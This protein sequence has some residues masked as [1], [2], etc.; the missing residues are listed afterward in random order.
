MNFKDQDLWVDRVSSWKSATDLVPRVVHNEIIKSELKPD[1]V[2]VGPKSLM[3]DP[4]SLQFAMGYKD[5]RYSLTYDV[6]KRIPQQLS[7]LAA[8]IQTR[9]NQVASF[10]VPF[11]LSKSLGFA[12]KHKNPARLTTKGEREFIQSLERFIYNCGA[13]APNPHNPHARDDFETFL[14]KVVRD[15]LMF[16]QL[17][18]EVVPDRKGQPYEFLA[19]DA[20]TIRIASD[21]SDLDFASAL[22]HANA[23][24]QGYENRALPQNTYGGHPYKT[25]KVRNP[26]IHDVPAYIQLLNGQIR[27]RYSRAELAFGVRNPRTDIYIQGYGYSELEQLITIITAHLF[28]EEY[29]RRFFMQGCVSG[30]TN[31]YSD[32]GIARI[33]SLVGQKLRVWNG[34]EFVDA[35]VV[36]SGIKRGFR[37]SL[38]S[39]SEIITTK[40]HKY[41]TFD[42]AGS[43]VMKPLSELSVGDYVAQSSSLVDFGIEPA[44]VQR[45]TYHQRTTVDAGTLDKDFYEFIGYLVGDGYISKL[46]RNKSSSKNNYTVSC[47]FGPKDTE[48]KDRFTSMLSSRGFKYH[49]SKSG[50][51]IGGAPLDTLTIRNKGLFDFLVD[52]V[53]VS[54]EKAH[55]KSVPSRLLSETAENRAAFLRGLFSADGFAKKNMAHVCSSSRKLIEGVQQLLWSL[56][57]H[58]TLSHVLKNASGRNC[59]YLRVSNNRKFAEIVGFI[60]SY[61]V[62]EPTKSDTFEKIPVVLQKALYAQMQGK[63]LTRWMSASQLRSMAEKTDMSFEALDY[64]WTRIENIEDIGLDIPVYDVRQTHGKHQW[65]AGSVIVSNSAPKGILNFRGDNLTPDQL[66]AFKRQWR[67]NVEGVENSWRTPVMQAEQGVEWIDLHPSN[68][69]WSTRCGSS[70]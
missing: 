66:E 6:L 25:M 30:E 34:Q 40:D 61:K 47:V 53:G 27:N 11:R 52:V 33:D 19:V 31:V 59:Y 35:D 23:M 64:R 32:K 41:L 48:V 5:R 44:Q 42:E 69:E 15:S 17:T 67:A 62:L 50:G 65:S 58:S 12:I 43:C 20:S 37:V 56:G 63:E 38:S 70:T 18:F 7:L 51:Q 68:Q 29:N 39:D 14:K 54:Q 2:G 10:S 57:I 1:K 22:R 4:L 26:E 55:L 28:A 3:G 24:N 60:Q 8:I 49:M 45:S 13:D 9:C 46:K 36:H 21:N 16:D